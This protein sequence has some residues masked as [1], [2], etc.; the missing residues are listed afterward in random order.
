MKRRWFV[1]CAVIVAMVFWPALSVAQGDGEATGGKTV[2]VELIFDVSGSMSQRVDTGQTRMDIAKRVLGEV[3]NVIPDRDGIN[4]GLRIYGFRGDNTEAT[5]QVS[6][7]SSELVV[8]VAG[9]DRASLLNEIEALEPIGWSPLA[10]SLLRAESDFPAAN[11]NVTN[12]IVLITD[13][14]DSCGGDPCDTAG[15]LASGE[16]QI[17]ISVI[18]IALT[19]AEQNTIDCIVEEG[20]G[21][22]FG[23][24]SASEWSEALFS[25]L[26]EGGVMRTG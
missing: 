22:L 21:L 18:G 15:D 11:E 26:E 16:A 3:I 17:S 1:A 20:N 4:V 14:L 2:N 12:A 8:P 25:V 24:A 19:A 6:C 7:T 9:V 13:G 10:F 5:K 23:S